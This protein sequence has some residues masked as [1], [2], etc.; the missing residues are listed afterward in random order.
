M[1]VDK[2]PKAGQCLR[3]NRGMTLKKK[4]EEKKTKGQMTA[5]EFSAFFTYQKISYNRLM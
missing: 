2:N 5:E 4:V 3:K 1:L